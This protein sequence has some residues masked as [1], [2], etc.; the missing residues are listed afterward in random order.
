LNGLGGLVDIGVVNFAMSG[1]VAEA[2][3]APATVL[4]F[5]SRSPL[6]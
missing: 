2:A 6:V 5:P 4:N 1:R 3:Y